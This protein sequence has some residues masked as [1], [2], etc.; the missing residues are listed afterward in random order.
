M[1]SDDDVIHILKW[2]ISLWR[3]T[4]T[5]FFP[6]SLLIGLFQQTDFQSILENLTV[7]T[8]AFSESVKTIFTWYYSKN[9]TKILE[10]HNELYPIF[11]KDKHGVLY[12]K[13][14]VLV[15][16]SSFLTIWTTK[17]KLLYPAYFP[18]DVNSSAF[19]FYFAKCFQHVAVVILIYWN[20]AYD[21]S[22]SLLIY[23]LKQKLKILSLRIEEIGKNTGEHSHV[24]LKEAVKHHLKLLE[25]YD[26]LN[27]LISWSVFGAFAAITLNLVSTLL[28][29][30]YYSDNI[31]QTLYY[32]ASLL[33][34]PMEIYLSCY[35]GSKF[36]TITNKLVTAIYSCN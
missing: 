13:T 22:Q 21:S 3:K 18:F 34:Y 2:C 11:I 33:A 5:F 28:M 4:V 26:L 6:L 15:C 30:M 8:T 24:L 36:I 31:F 1:S 7:I 17:N 29:I 20:I 35:Y 19:N 32:L 16:A 14:Y 27:Q 10:I 23:L 12:Y 9:I 25:F